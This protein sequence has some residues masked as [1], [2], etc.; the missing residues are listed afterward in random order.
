MKTK[1]KTPQASK[2]SKDLLSSLV[3]V[4]VLSLATWFFFQQ[5]SMK[6]DPAGTMVVVGGWFLIVFLSKII[7]SRVRWKK[8]A[9]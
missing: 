7:W 2:P 9:K 4:L 6:L 8:G 1:S 3:I 5:A